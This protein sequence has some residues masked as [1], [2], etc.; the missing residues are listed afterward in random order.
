MENKIVVERIDKLTVKTTIKEIPVEGGE[1]GEKERK[2]VTQV[3][4][5]YE[6]TPGVMDG[7]LTAQ[8]AEHRLDVTI[9]SPQLAFAGISHKEGSN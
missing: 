3:S 7:M 8:L 9:G 5:E 6:G 2:M 4:F 1:P